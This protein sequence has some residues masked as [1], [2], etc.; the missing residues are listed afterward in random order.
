MQRRWIFWI[1]LATVAADRVLKIW[2]AATMVPGQSITVI[3]GVL[4]ITYVLNSGAA[5]SLLRHSTGLFIAVAVVLL[6]GVAYV[7]WKHVQLPRRT[8]WGLGLLAGGSAG[9]LWDRV[10]TGRVIDYL[11]FRFWAVFNLAD[12]SIVIG[13]GLLVWEYWNRQEANQN[14]QEGA[15]GTSEG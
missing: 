15:D 7:A 2:V 1:A 10:V 3:P 11:H 13:M 5:F 6:A 14:A 9:N 4:W 8:I 12:A